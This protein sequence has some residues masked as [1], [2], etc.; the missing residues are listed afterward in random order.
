MDFELTM[1]GILTCTWLFLP[2]LSHQSKVVNRVDMLMLASSFSSVGLAYKTQNGANKA[3]S[4]FFSSADGNASLICN[5][6]QATDVASASALASN[7]ASASTLANNIAGASTRP[8]DNGK[9]RPMTNANAGN[10]SARAPT[11]STTLLA[12]RQ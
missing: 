9:L 7:L 11:S 2:L 12:F 4:F 5:D 6:K 8:S 1:T 3:F 10:N